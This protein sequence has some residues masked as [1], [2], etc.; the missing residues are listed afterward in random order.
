MI[1]ASEYE[2]VTDAAALVERPGRVV[3]RVEGEEAADFLQ[4]QVTNDV[5]ALAPGAGCYAAVLSAKGKLRA[6][7]RVLRLDDAFLLDGEPIAG[8]VLRH[9]LTTYALGR[10][11]R[12]REEE[13]AVVSIM[14]TSTSRA[15]GSDS[16]RYP[17]SL[18]R[19]RRSAR[20]FPLWLS[21]AA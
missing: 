9:M 11:V 18:R 5:E 21:S 10:D 4:G 16:S 15:I 19:T 12:F 7:M 13:A 1:A 3:L 20:S 17:S 2:L 14:C 6:D 8:P